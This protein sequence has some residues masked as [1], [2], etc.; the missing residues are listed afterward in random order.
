MTECYICCH[1]NEKEIFRVKVTWWSDCKLRS[2]YDFYEVESGGEIDDHLT[3]TGQELREIHESNLPPE[4]PDNG[5]LPFTPWY[6]KK[7]PFIEGQIDAII[8][9]AEA[10]DKIEI[11]LFYWSSGY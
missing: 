1:K 10:Y 5:N 4:N 11:V 2:K 9:S 3:V 6:R 7:D 8:K